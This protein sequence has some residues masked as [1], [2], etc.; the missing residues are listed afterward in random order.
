MEGIRGPVKDAFL[1]F[2]R[3]LDWQTASDACS[4]MK[5]AIK[6]TPNL[7][8]EIRKILKQL[9]HTMGRFDLTGQLQG[10]QS[11]KQICQIEWKRI[12]EDSVSRV[13]NYQTLGLCTGAALAILFA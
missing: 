8:K 6:K 7:P 13:R 2:S 4:C 9:G 11:V 12:S 1:N 10:I 5:A 3:E